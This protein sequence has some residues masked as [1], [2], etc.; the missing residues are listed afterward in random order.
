MP[1]FTHDGFDLLY[2][3]QPPASGE[4]VPVLL[5]HGF[6]STHFVNWVF[7]DHN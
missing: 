4:G 5:I 2:L 3:D 7:T 1:F 6:A